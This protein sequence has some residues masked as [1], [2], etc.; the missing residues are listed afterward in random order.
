MNL[1]PKTT[2]HNLVDKKE[3]SRMKKDKNIKLMDKIIGI[4][5]VIDNYIIRSRYGYSII[6]KIST[7]D[8]TL[9]S[10]D[11]MEQFENLLISFS[12]G[13]NFPIKYAR[14]NKKQNFKNYKEFVNQFSEDV[15]RNDFIKGYK[16]QIYKELDQMERGYN[17]TTKSNYIYV[18]TPHEAIEERTLKEL[19]D[20]VN[21]VIRALKDVNVRLDLL[22]GAEIIEFFHQQF[23]KGTRLYLDKLVE[24]G[25]FNE[26]LGPLGIKDKVEK[27]EHSIIKRELN[28]M[29]SRGEI[30]GVIGTYSSNDLIEVEL[31]PGEDYKR[32][33][34]ENK[35]LEELKGKDKKKYEK[36]LIKNDKKRSQKKEVKQEETSKDIL[37]AGRLKIYDIIKPNIFEETK[38]YIKFGTKNFVRLLVV[39]TLPQS[40]NVNT[41]NS[42]CSLEDMEM[43]TILKKIPEGSLSKSLKSRHS[44]IQANIDMEYK[45]TGAIDYEKE[46][47][48]AN[49]DDMRRLIETNSDK[50]FN[51]QTIIKIWADNLKELE[52]K[53]K[54]FMDKCASNAIEIRVLFY[55]QRDALM[56]TLPFNSFEFGEDK[57]NITTGGACCLVPNGCTDLE[58]PE[59]KYLGRNDNTNAA[60][61]FDNFLCQ[62]PY[63]KGYELYSNPN[64]YICGKMGS[65][66]STAMKVLM[67]RGSLIGEWHAVF[68]MEN[69]YLS[70][71]KH[72]G[73]IYLNLKSS[74]HIGINPLE[75]SEEEDDNGNKVVPIADRVQDVI[76]L[77]NNFVAYYDERKLTATEIS[78]IQESILKIYSDKGITEDPS[79]LYDQ[80]GKKKTLP[81]LSDLREAIRERGILLQQ[82]SVEVGNN[83]IKIAE[84][85]GVITGKGVMNMFD[86]QTSEEITNFR[87]N[88]MVVFCLKELDE[89]T[90]SY[91]M[92]TILNWLWGLYSDWRYKGIQKNVWIDEG[93]VLAKHESSLALIENFSRRG[94]KY[95]ISLIIST[96]AIS[97][98][99]NSRAG[100]AIIKLCSTKLLFRQD[101]SLSHQIGELFDLPIEIQKCMPAFAKGQCVMV[102][103]TGNLIA[104]VDLFECEK[105]FATT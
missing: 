90:K 18:F 74:T 24:Q 22:E 70:T 85:M 87:K 62:K 42:M 43:I 92:T 78:G 59:G 93:W 56:T 71:C 26:L 101:A 67:G 23:N 40:I 31:V 32:I 58:H 44:K 21:Y 33:E 54:I 94:R 14:S 11:E 102:T 13:L 72:F 17:S 38:D 80:N 19:Q 84:T 55:D 99:L 2:T 100:D 35:K 5:K 39:H 63:I 65:G 53:T 97:E 28:Q 77:I 83:L 29:I 27:L 61:I 16:E 12:F 82:Q 25:V 76:N 10:E 9:L 95:W 91:A 64:Y 79:S 60:I 69:E 104:N 45:Q 4:E 48:A 46:E 20:K 66:K 41:L 98:F 105:V 15:D 52:N 36:E 7:T 96:Q 49:I 89:T 47:A 75:I 68:D 86:C 37:E 50:L 30:D 1:N 81:I 57:R 88:K 51:T 34:S 8:T 6:L 73:G 103:D 3:I